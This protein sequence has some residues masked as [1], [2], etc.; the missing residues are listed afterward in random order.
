MIE[1]P[2]SPSSCVI[3]KSS[4]EMRPRAPCRLWQQS[5][6]SH[7]NARSGTGSPRKHRGPRRAAARL[8]QNTGLVCFI[9]GRSQ[10]QTGAGKAEA[11][12][13]KAGARTA[14]DLSGRSPAGALARAR[15]EEE[16]TEEVGGHSGGSRFRRC[17]AG[18][19]LSAQGCSRNL[20]TPS[21]WGS[22]LSVGIPYRPGSVFGA[23]AADASW[24]ACDPLAGTF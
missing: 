21:P 3:A 5:C 24:D 7:Q 22:Y 23:D 11:A 16:G 15:S 6:S 8:G 9:H 4:K 17:P 12:G 1:R 2:G 20:L 14:A 19:S 10:T 18:E 13:E